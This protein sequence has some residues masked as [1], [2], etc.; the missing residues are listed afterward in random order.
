MEKE[1]MELAK[2]RPDMACIFQVLEKK[3]PRF[4]VYRTYIACYGLNDITSYCTTELRDDIIPL[5]ANDKD[6]NKKIAELGYDPEDN[7]I[8]S[9]LLENGPC[10]L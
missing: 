10:S 3:Y 2:T 1:I 5:S 7:V 8:Y 4:N 6:L 9:F